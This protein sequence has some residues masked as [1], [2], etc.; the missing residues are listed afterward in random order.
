MLNTYKRD[1]RLKRTLDLA[2]QSQG[3][4]HNHIFGIGIDVAIARGRSGDKGDTCNIGIV[5]RSPL[6]YAWLREMSHRLREKYHL[7]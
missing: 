5:A 7:L 6:A 2:E 1:L 3:L 4:A